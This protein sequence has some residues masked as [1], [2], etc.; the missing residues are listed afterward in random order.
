M[1]TIKQGVITA[2][3]VLLA[4][5]AQTFAIED[6]KIKVVCPDVVLSW[7]SA[8][9]ETYIVQYRATLD[10]N[11][12]W[13]TLTNSLPAVSSTNLTTF[14]HSNMVDCPAGQVFGMMSGGGG[15][16]GSSSLDGAS[17][18]EDSKPTEPMIMPK[19]E[20]SPPAP[21]Q[22]FPPGLDLSGW[23]IIW[24]DGSTEEWTKEFAEKYADAQ[25]NG[26][27]DPEP[28]NGGGGG[29][30]GCGFYR[31]VRV[32]IHLFGI[33]SGQV[34]LP[35]EFGNP[36]TNGTLNQVFLSNNDS[37]E[38]ITGTT[39]PDFPLDS[40]SNLSGVWDT[41][42]VTN[43]T[44]TLV[45]G[46]TLDN[47]TVYLD[48]PITVTVVNA[49]WFPDPWMVGGQA[50]Y[51]G[52]QT[53]YTSGTWL[54]ELY[55]DYDTYLGYLDG[56]ID[57]NGYCAYPGIP[58]PGFSLDNTDG[59]GNQNP[60]TS[61]TMV[62]TVTPPGNAPSKTVTKKPFIEPAW[63][64]INTTAVIC[65]MQV[66]S[67]SQD[68]AQELFNLMQLI[69]NIEQPFHQNL[70]GTFV[71]PYEVQTSNDWVNVAFNLSSFGNRDFF[72]FGHGDGSHLG[73]NPTRELTVSDVNFILQ[74]NMSDPLTATNRHPYRFVFLDGC[75]TA[76]GNW[77]QA[78]GIPK[79]EGMV[80][81]DF[82]AKR[83]IRPRAFMGW[84]RKKVF[85]S[86]F[87]S[88]QL[89]GPHE[90]YITTFWQKWAERQNGLP[91]RNI[92]EAIAL[93]KAAAA[94]ASLGMMLYGAEDLFID[95]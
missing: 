73:P 20:S 75:N 31:V 76:D 60:S 39:F 23:I 86:I 58:G 46:A 57:T 7:P 35:L 24:P 1:K 83:G 32:G 90:T 41:T 15:S 85:S 64:S 91:V 71:V 25:D 17:E 37:D 21:L 53:I 95:Y 81:T 82:G 84:N 19:D 54:L 78:F 36:N 61:Y 10:T 30:P 5:I 48:N 88:G 3:A 26:L 38:E 56:P 40:T 18:Q 63:D 59:N 4:S 2:A 69:W 79:K 94:N 47:E 45:M 70:L 16:G 9:G 12:A 6:L 62:I 22:I 28:E 11:D 87:S 14:V 51:V 29:S 66:F 34:T 67:Q 52:A 72:Y 74:N 44:Y 42:Q 33:T 49:I 77:P 55:D 50:I 13:V 65:Y 43:G 68:G 93:A 80:A 89:H 92:K 27:D 8:E